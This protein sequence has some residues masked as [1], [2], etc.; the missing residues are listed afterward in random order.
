VIA[1][2]VVN[3]PVLSASVVVGQSSLSRL[4]NGS[5]IRSVPASVKA[6]RG[7]SIDTLIFDEA[8]NSA[9]R[10]GDYLDERLIRTGRSGDDLVFGRTASDPFSPQ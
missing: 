6:I 9:T 8:A 4:T 10:S 7:W 1:E 5:T 3:S 2:L